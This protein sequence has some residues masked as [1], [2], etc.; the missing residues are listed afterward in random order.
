MWPAVPPGRIPA[1]LGVEVESHRSGQ[2]RTSGRDVS[3]PN[4]PRQQFP[5]K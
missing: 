4:L 5:K 3:H 2:G 1:Y